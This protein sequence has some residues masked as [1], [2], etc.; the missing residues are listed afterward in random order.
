MRVRVGGGGSCVCPWL[1]KKQKKSFNNGT[2][3]LYLFGG[4]GMGWIENQKKSVSVI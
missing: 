3:G 4:R 1:A 2:H